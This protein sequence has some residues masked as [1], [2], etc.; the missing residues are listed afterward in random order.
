MSSVPA[1]LMVPV[2]IQVRE[3]D[4]K[5]LLAAAAAER[6]FPVILGS[7]AFVHFQASRLPRGVYLAKSMRRLSI[8]MFALLRRLGHAIV[9]Y[10]EDGL[11]RAPDHEYYRWRLSEATVPQVAHLMAWGP[12]DAAVLGRYPGYRG[13]PIHVT[14]NPRIDL[15]RPE[16]REYHRPAV[17]AIRARFGEF[18]LVNTNFNKV[19]HFFAELSQLRAAAEAAD[20]AAHPF[21]IGKG[22]HKLA[23]FEHFRALLPRLCEALAD[24][25]VVL[26]PH[27]EENHAPWLELARRCSNL[28]VVTEG[29][30]APWL[31]AARALVANSCTTMVE[32]AVLDVPT[33]NFEP[34]RSAEYDYALPGSLGRSA[35]TIEE[36]CEMARA[37]AQG[38]LGP[39][40][41]AERRTLLAPH[42]AALDGPLAADR[43]VDVLAEAG[44]LDGP[45]P[46]PPLL[47][48]ARGWLGN[49]LRAVRKRVNMRR[50]GHRNN[51]AYHAHRFPD[52]GVEDVRARVER[53][54]R[55]LG[56]FK[57]VRVEPHGAHVFR[58][59]R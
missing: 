43:M 45:P 24:R 46:A 32:A 55:L 8:R 17:D 33:V 56:R 36:A 29:T 37:M 52:I 19:N 2:E 9:A 27:P 21:E 3:M 26:R 28:R 39:L 7:R 40:D 5:I 30:V 20:P 25:T 6:G 15:M 44:Y 12:D 42:L 11:V 13:A 31:L 18:V 53:L 34:V 51:L 10:D 22:R 4:A 1:L 54:G 50:P 38:T 58:F 57:D 49:E 14:G 16:L 35:A 41:L 48:R 47:A 59:G 23:L